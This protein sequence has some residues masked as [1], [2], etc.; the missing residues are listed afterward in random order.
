MA[1]ALLVRH[2]SLPVLSFDK[3]GT[4]NNIYVTLLPKA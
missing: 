3:E 2:M 1:W 4:L